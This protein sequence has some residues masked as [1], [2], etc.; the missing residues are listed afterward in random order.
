MKYI[1]VKNYLAKN[2]DLLGIFFL[3]SGVFALVA[4]FVYTLMDMDVQVIGNTIG[5]ML[6]LFSVGLGLIA[7]SMSARSDQRYT[8]LLERLDKNVTRLP[9][10]LKN[11]I[12][13]PSGRLLANEMLTEQSKDVAQ[14]RLDEDK[15]RVGYVRGEVYQLSDGT[16][17]I[18]WGGKYSL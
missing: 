12:L 3:I 18:H 16:W 9:T 1:K 5:L 13:T 11:D 2:G 4:A 10:L 15:Q 14:K 8:V 17:A 7:F 6:G